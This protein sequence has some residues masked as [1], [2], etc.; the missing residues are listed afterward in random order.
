MSKIIFLIIILWFRACRFTPRNYM[1][2]RKPS[3]FSL[4]AFCRYCIIEAVFLLTSKT[5]FA[6]Y[7][8]QKG[9][10]CNPSRCPRI[11]IRVNSWIRVFCGG[12]K[13]RCCVIP[14]TS[15]PLFWMYILVHFWR[16]VL[17][18]VKTSI[19]ATSVP[20]L[21]VH[22]C[23]FLDASFLRSKKH[24]CCVELRTSL[25][26]WEGDICCSV[27]HEFVWNQ[28]HPWQ[29]S[30]RQTSSCQNRHL[31]WN[32]YNLNFDTVWAIYVYN[33]FYFSSL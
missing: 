31:L 13:H 23:Q 17:P 16:R 30:A 26:V 7:Q 6:T 12:K 18:Y 9:Y 1:P 21:N 10:R 20:L 4:V 3:G 14:A 27:E 22:P 15:V 32:L 29:K 24:R 11:D 2:R 19:P 5:A 25:S 8:R 33:K 28:R